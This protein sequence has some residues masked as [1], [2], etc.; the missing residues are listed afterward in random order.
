[1][2]NYGLVNIVK[3][4]LGSQD[5]LRKAGIVLIFHRKWDHITEKWTS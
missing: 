5:C 4:S 2:L 3:K 1:M